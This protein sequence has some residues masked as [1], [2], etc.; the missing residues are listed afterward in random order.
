MVVLIL[1]E[2]ERLMNV[3]KTVIVTS[4]PFA[5]A[6]VNLLMATKLCTK[7]QVW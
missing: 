1:R 4:I 6:P 3:Y 7:Y 5:G 2:K